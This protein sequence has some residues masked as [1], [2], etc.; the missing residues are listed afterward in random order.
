MKH[1]FALLLIIAVW[2]AAS[3]AFGAQGQAI[4]V[5]PSSINAYSQGATS[6]LLTFRNVRDKRPVEGCWCAEVVSAAPDLGA[7]CAP[8]TQ[9]GCLPVR[10]NQATLN[11][12][13]AY[14]D[15]MSIPPSVARR[16][17]LDAAQGAPAVF[18]YVRRF[19]S[20]TGGV[21]EFVAVTIR[22]AG[23]GAAT[24]FSLTN[25]KLAFA[26]NKP[27]LFL[28]AGEKVPKIQAEITYTG[29]GR[30]Q[31]RWE[32]VKPGDELPT[33]RDLLTE[34][35]LPVEARGTQ[36][37]YQQLSRFTIYLP[38]TGKFVLSGPESWRLQNPVEGMYLVL[39]RIES[40]E[41]AN[42]TSGA[43][44]ASGGVA[45]FPLPVLRYYIGSGGVSALDVAPGSLKLLSPAE[46]AE[47]PL[48]RA[49]DFHWSEVEG[50]A[51]YRIEI[52]SVRTAAGSVASP[53][54]NRAPLLAAILLPGM[55]LYRA[56]A[57]LT[58]TLQK[59]AQEPSQTGASHL[60][61]WR[62]VALAADGKL[63][64]ETGWRN[65]RLRR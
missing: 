27:V 49:P 34:A 52:A 39:L 51:Y 28:K 22:L 20:T 8:A 21:D 64:A 13:G 59:E 45:G 50:A 26:V 15:I 41:D 18:Y 6:A 62:V 1:R 36:R 42:Q 30:L 9:F 25:I 65:L 19:A 43:R 46:N 60:L 16:A 14:T 55:P 4:E 33:A 53:E 29:S 5:S 47:L 31:G 56:P 7:R 24:P 2:L 38:P 63:L 35:T 44:L 48:A 32:I 57:F 54:A 58:E 12:G 37:R 11:A 3:L 23:N 10:Y 17:Y 61:Q 40:V